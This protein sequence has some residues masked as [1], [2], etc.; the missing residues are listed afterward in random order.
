LIE[1]VP[2]QG[3]R[4]INKLVKQPFRITE[5]G[6]LF[7][8]IIERWTGDDGLEGSEKR[9]GLDRDNDVRRGFCEDEKRFEG[10][11]AYN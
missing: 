3:K 10:C 2:K 9:D 1:E 11:D 8:G 7:L 5:K 6:L 4:E